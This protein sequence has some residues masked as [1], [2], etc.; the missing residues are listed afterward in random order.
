MG[1]V[2]MYMTLLSSTESQHQQHLWT[3][4]LTHT[5]HHHNLPRQRS[6]MCHLRGGALVLAVQERG[7]IV[8]EARLTVAGL[9]H[10]G[11]LLMPPL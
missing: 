2:L 4:I 7:V 1:Y 8:I 11:G 6:V 10:Q 9:L 5:T 3:H